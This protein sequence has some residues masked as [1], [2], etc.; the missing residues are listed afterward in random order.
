MLITESWIDDSHPW[1][2]NERDLKIFSN[3]E[4]IV[5][6]QRNRLDENEI[7]NFVSKYILDQLDEKIYNLDLS[8][9]LSQNIAKTIRQELSDKYKFYK[10]I[11]QTFVGKISNNLNSQ[12]F[13]LYASYRFDQRTDKYLSIIQN[14]GNM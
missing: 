14:N 2:I 4:T 5:E 6:R 10:I 1:K 12:N 3:Y 13:K 11:I 9:Q 8:I 7:Q